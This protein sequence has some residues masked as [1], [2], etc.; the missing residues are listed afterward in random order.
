[1][2][3][4]LALASAHPTG[5]EAK[6]GLGDLARR[7]QR[8]SHRILIAALAGALTSVGFAPIGLWPATVVGVAGFALASHGPHS[9]RRAAAVGTAFG[10]VFTAITLN[11]MRMIDPGAAAGLIVA[12][13]TWYAL[14]G[15]ATNLAFRTRA[16]PV[17]SAGLWLAMEYAASRF[18]FGGFGW[19]RLG[20]T[21]LDSPLSGLLPLVGVGGLSFAT[22]L[23]A[24]SLAWVAIRTSWRRV[25]ALAALIAGL[26]LAALVGGALP[27]PATTGNITLGWVQGGAP[28]G[29]VYGIGAERSTSYRH[30]SQ[31]AKLAEE[32]S[33]GRADVPDAVIWPENATDLD[34]RVDATTRSLIEASVAAARAPILVG[35]ILKGP[36]QDERQTAS[37]WWTTQG[38]G[39]TYIKRSLVP[40]GEWIPFRDVLLPLIPQLRYVGAQSV[41][42]TV[43][44][45][46]P[47]TL[48]DGRAATVGVL[49]CF[50]VAFDQV[51]IDLPDNGAQIIVVQ[52]SNAMYQGSSQVD[53]QF[54]I[55]RARAAELKREV[56]VVTTSG[57]SGIIGP[58]GKP[59]LRVEQ[60]AASG[61]T[62]LP[63]R[64]GL[65][66]AAMI[67]VPLQQVLSLAFLAWLALLARRCY[68]R[69]AIGIRNRYTF[70]TVKTPSSTR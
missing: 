5:A 40:F 35:T 24:Q 52:S 12:M 22:A 46:L 16:W 68:M 66:P 41:P 47:V 69:W 15:V 9:G 23:L 56:L 51:A 57:V 42:G 1:M 25:S 58:D 27:P 67:S 49:L 11:W 63:L 4:N 54:A 32:I 7:S 37:Q 62:T 28:G 13:T 59:R 60:G 30:A 2:P 26:L 64:N 53:Q 34:P 14:L 70:I 39:P 18:P 55:T 38:A 44:G 29:G 45:T 48:R 8:Q 10:F 36:G 43:A 6:P 65:T 20:Y 17:L 33:S 50:D 61:V 3:E 19:L 21:M 31:T